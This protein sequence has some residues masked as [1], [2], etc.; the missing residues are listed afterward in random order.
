VRAGLNELNDN[1]SFDFANEMPVG[2]IVVGRISKI[3]EP[4]NAP[5]RYNFSTRQSLVVYGV[6]GID[7]SKL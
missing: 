1:A 2:R 5:K 4:T 6:G 7:R 3:D